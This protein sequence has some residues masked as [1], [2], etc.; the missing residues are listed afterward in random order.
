MSD[1]LKEEEKVYSDEYTKQKMLIKCEWETKRE[2]EVQ[3]FIRAQ[4]KSKIEELLDD[5]VK[6]H[7]VIPLCLYRMQVCEQTQ[8]H[9]ARTCLKK[10]FRCRIM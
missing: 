7:I 6:C 10:C 4:H 5:N 8:P 1:H 9:L 3:L 2:E